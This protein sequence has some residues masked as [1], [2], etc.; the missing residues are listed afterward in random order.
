MP[1]GGHLDELGDTPV[2]GVD[3]L[4]RACG[5]AGIG[6]PS[7]C[8]PSSDEPPGETA[9]FQRN[10]DDF[11]GVA[12][13]RTVEAF[14]ASMLPT[15]AVNVHGFA[16][17]EG[18]SAFNE[19][20][21]CARALKVVGVLLAKGV[22]PAQIRVFSHGARPGDAA[23]RRTT[24]LERDPPVSRRTVPRLS[25]TVVTGPT[26]GNCGG[27]TFVL[28]WSLSQNAGPQGGFVIQAVTFD[29][30]VLDCTG[31]RVPNPDPRTSPLTYF[32]AWRVAPN[33]QTLSPIA[34]DTFFWPDA[35]P[36]AGGCTDGAVRITAEARYHDDVPALPAGMI[37]NNPATFAGI[38]QSSRSDPALAEPAS[39][40]IDHRLAFHWVCCPCS[41]SPTVIDAHAP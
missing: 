37:A 11:S 32:E 3:T 38:L 9:L 35:P 18:P 7:G 4:Q 24:V 14:A 2:A 16:S 12:Q 8:T 36:W 30:E 5:P 15:D 13:Q 23:L 40:A 20:L 19:R 27:T 31:T 22:S 26:V 21:S 6:S 1:R 25:G 29:W 17:I 39:N 10:C 34:T 33:S 28:Q 41:S